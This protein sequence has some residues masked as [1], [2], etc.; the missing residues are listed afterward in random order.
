MSAFHDALRLATHD[1][2]YPVEG[3]NTIVTVLAVMV[4]FDRAKGDR[5]SYQQWKEAGILPQIV[6]EILSL[7]P[8]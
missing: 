8:M 4:V 2:R 3:S 1:I 6:F 7:R 5:G